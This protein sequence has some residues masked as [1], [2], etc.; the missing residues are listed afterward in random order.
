MHLCSVHVVLTFIDMWQI[1]DV[2][3][4][5]AFIGIALAHIYIWKHARFISIPLPPQSSGQL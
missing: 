2:Y 3:M 4:Y 5:F 1:Y